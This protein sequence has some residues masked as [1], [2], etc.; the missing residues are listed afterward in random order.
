M[1][2]AS[3]SRVPVGVAM[4]VAYTAPILV[5]IWARFVWRRRISWLAVAGAGLAAL[6]LAAVVQIWSGIRVDP[7]GLLLA[8]SA[9]CC[10]AAY[11]LLSESLTAVNPI[12]LLVWGLGIGALALTPLAAP[13]NVRWSALLADVDVGPWTVS[14]AAVLAWLVL[15]ST[16]AAYVTGVA[17]VRQ[18][19]SPLASV[20][21]SLEVPVSAIVA[22]AVLGERLAPIQWAGM[23]LV[24]S[25][26]V[27]AHRAATIAPGAGD[28]PTPHQLARKLAATGSLSR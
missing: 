17:A 6:G 4:L 1:F 18:L 7:V 12:T 16:I 23:V 11:F 9:A 10:L 21:A 20:L 22:L 27:L 8:F 24:L 5:L 19:S 28:R 15:V 25:G 26:S 3:V 2:F 13:W 14:A